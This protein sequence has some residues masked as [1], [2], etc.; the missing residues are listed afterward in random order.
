MRE[1]A[2][3]PEVVV[4]SVISNVGEKPMGALGSI[5]TP[6]PTERTGAVQ[7]EDRDTVRPRHEVHPIAHP[8]VH[9]VIEQVQRVLL[10]VV[11]E[12]LARDRL[13]R[14]DGGAPRGTTHGQV[15]YLRVLVLARSSDEER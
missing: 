9:E 13:P 11:K 1:L 14:N 15:R 12:Y 4:A 8:A 6:G 5:G 7:G 10:D 3:R 2:M